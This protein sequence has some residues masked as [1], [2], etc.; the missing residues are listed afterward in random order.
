[1]TSGERQ[2]SPALTA[3][4]FGPPGQIFNAS[5][6]G[7]LPRPGTLPPGRGVSPGPAAVCSDQHFF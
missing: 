3:S 1:M 6:V 2:M 5:E 4:T 7:T